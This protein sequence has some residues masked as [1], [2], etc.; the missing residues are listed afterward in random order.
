M[1]PATKKVF[2]E[3]NDNLYYQMFTR[4]GWEVVD[5]IEEADLVQFTGGADVSPELYNEEM[6]RATRAN[7][8]R[9]LTEM[10]LFN[11]CKENSIPM[12]GICRGGQFLNVMCGGSMYQHVNNHALQGTHPVIELETGHRYHCTST[13]HQMMIPGDEGVLVGVASEATVCERMEGR[14]VVY[15]EQQR[16]DDV[17]V[18]KYPEAKVLCFQPH[19]E[20]MEADAP[21]QDW[22]FNLVNELIGE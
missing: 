20:Y 21:C 3:Y 18:V 9:D 16:G 7:M 2:I 19:P 8:S 11:K 1:K 6:H 10:E 13:H 17:E 4:R 22:Y 5:S 12:T 15:V 14:R